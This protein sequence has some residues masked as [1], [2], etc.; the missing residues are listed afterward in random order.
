MLFKSLN[1]CCV[2]F[3]PVDEFSKEFQ[4]EYDA[5]V[6]ATKMITDLQKDKSMW[7]SYKHKLT[8]FF[9]TY[10]VELE[11]LNVEFGKYIIKASAQNTG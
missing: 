3:Y 5:R 6:K 1:N 7:I 2:V 10:L 4:K 8:R 9:H 11:I